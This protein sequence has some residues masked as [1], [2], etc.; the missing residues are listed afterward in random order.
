ML[1]RKACFGKLSM[2]KAAGGGSSLAGITLARF[3]GSNLRSFVCFVELSMT[4]K[5][6]GNCKKAF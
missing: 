2:T 1:L 4:I 6:P 3:N 5:H